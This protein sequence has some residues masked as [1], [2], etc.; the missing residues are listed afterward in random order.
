M[1][2]GSLGTM[3]H[4]DIPPFVCALKPLTVTRMLW[5]A[6]IAELGWKLRLGDAA[7]ASMATPRSPPPAKR[8]VAPS[9]AN[10]CVVFPTGRT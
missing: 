5:V 10:R 4:W 6:P 1:M 8:M 7:P 9:M 3:G 2:V